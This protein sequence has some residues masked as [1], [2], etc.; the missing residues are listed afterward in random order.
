[1]STPRLP[2]T[3]EVKTPSPATSLA[4][5]WFFAPIVSLRGSSS[6]SPTGCTGFGQAAMP[7]VVE[8]PPVGGG[9][10]QRQHRRRVAG[11][12]RKHR[13]FVRAERHRR[14]PG[15]RLHRLREPVLD[16]RQPE[17]HLRR[18]GR[19][20]RERRRD[21]LDPVSVRADD[22]FERE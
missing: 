20:E 2:A 11:E 14:R 18:A 1:M 9:T 22:R 17:R 5:A 6:F 21:D 3:A 19:G 16:R 4:M 12:R 13:R 15:T 10:D 8:G 7:G